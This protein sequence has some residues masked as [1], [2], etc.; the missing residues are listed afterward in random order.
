MIGV[1]VY[2]YFLAVGFLYAD[3]LYRE[4]GIFFRSWMGGVFGNVLLMAGM[5]IPS[6]IFGFTVVS[7]ITLIVLSIVPYFVI[8]FRKKEA[9]FSKDLFRTD[10]EDCLDLK[11]FLIVILP[12]T[13]L[14]CLLMANHIFAPVDGGVASG[15]STYGDLAIH[16]GMITSMVEQGTFPPDY[17]ILAGTKLS[18]PFFIN[19]LSSSLYLFGLPLRWA[20]LLPSFVF[21]LLLVM[22]FYHLAYK[23][24]GRKSVSI[25]AVLMFFLNGGLG[26]AYFFEGAKA[27]PHEFT[28]IFTDYYHTPTNFN[29]MN[30]RWA[31]TIC[32]MIIPQRTTMAGWCTVMTALWMLIDAVKSNK[33][34]A[35]IT[36]GVFAGC[37]P[38]IH[39]HSF[40]ALGI[41]SA[42]M[43]LLYLPLKK[44][45][46]DDKKK[47]KIG[48]DNSALK[49]YIINWALF[50]GITLI[51]AMPQLIFWTFQQASE[52]SFLSFKYDW[53]ND[54]DPFLWFWIKNWG[55]IFLAAIP[56]FMNAD[57][58][59]KKLMISAFAVFVV[60]DLVLFQPLEYDNNKLFFV[61]YMIAIAA[62]ANFLV[63]AYEQMK[64]IKG[65]QVIAF[66]V[67]VG[68]FLSGI[69][70]IGREYKSGSDYQTFSNDE[71]E[72]AEFV[73]DNTDPHAIFATHTDHLNVISCLAGRTI[74]VGAQM[75]IW[76][77]GYNDEFVRRDA[78]L[79]SLYESQDVN[80]LKRIAEEN[81]IT[82]I[83]YTGRESDKYTTNKSVFD[84]LNKIYDQNGIALYEIS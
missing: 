15:Q 67:A 14:I 61:A 24:T 23:I 77:H 83:L 49:E 65:R 58:D 33:R 50:G 36:I 72:F 5:V 25:L 68:L 73:K 60:A 81:N 20:I 30:I 10:G 40:V 12:V 21:A 74:F 8:K 56:A 44:E 1:I 70:T 47:K 3:M 76:T 7:H 42:V 84:Q 63:Y 26:F 38:M 6:F 80:E 9:F 78:I 54:N 29:E 69:L 66:V 79:K 2:L 46:D 16:S 57:K 55:V 64:N 52:G 59:I 37:M 4:K 34:K 11:T 13:I 18:Y 19:M 51:M 48:T 32:D 62:V 41:I 17:N 28:K 22:G 82:Y 71:L 27:N 45:T 39:T 35:F 31:N 43:L 75:F 53:V